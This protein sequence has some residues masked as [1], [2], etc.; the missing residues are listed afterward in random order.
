MLEDILI[1]LS[2]LTRRDLEMALRMTGKVMEA[3]DVQVAHFERSGDISVIPRE[4]EP[5]LKV[6]DVNV[7]NG[8]QTVRI[9]LSAG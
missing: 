9:E 4:K 7:L 5:Q 8:V 3:S 2:D 6:V 1:S